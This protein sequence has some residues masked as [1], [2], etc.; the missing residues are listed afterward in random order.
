M[1]D[2]HAYDAKYLYQKRAVAFLDVLG[3]RQKL[4]DFE[5]EAEV[6]KSRLSSEDDESAGKYMSQKTNDFINAFKVAISSLDKSKY[7]YYLF[8]DNICISSI[9]ET[10]AADL[11]DLLLVITKLFFEF[12][13]RGYFLRG[14]I[15]YGLFIDEETIAIGNPLAV[16][17]ELETKKAVY[18]R[19]VLSQR[20]IDEFQSFNTDFKKEFELFYS[21]ALIQESCEIKY[22]NVFL[23][24]FQSD[25]REDRESFF[26]K[27]N[28]VI[29]QNLE[30]NKNNETVFVKYKWLA[31]Q[32]N[33]FIDSFTGHLAFMDTDF[34]PD[35][36]LGFLDFIKQQK[37]NYAN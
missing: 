26:L 37:I 32:F 33:Q 23:H 24:V 14:G 35:D 15:D 12:A 5:K 16:A 19:I 28:S 8:S 17:Y 4:T 18:P 10:T 3:F 36:E 31:E 30:H 21:S 25:Y 1:E 11:Q 22:L 7:R 9:E 13:Q 2:A 6:N 27:F 29:S 34:N 20:L